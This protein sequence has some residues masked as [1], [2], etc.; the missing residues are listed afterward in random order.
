MNSP[1]NSQQ[2]TVRPDLLLSNFSLEM[3]AK[4]SEALADAAP[5]L[6]PGT[7][8]SITYLPGETSAARVA[9]A[10]LVRQLGFLP[11]PHIS[12][13]RLTSQVE[14]DDCL[15]D[16]A[17]EAGL[18]R[19]FVVAGDCDP[20]GPFSDA[21]DIIRSGRLSSFGVVR[22]GIAGYPEG[23]PAIPNDILWRALSDKHQLLLELGH[24][25]I[26]TTQFA[27]D[28]DAMLTWVEEVRSRGITSTIRLGV[29]GPASVK[30]LLRF[31]ARCGVG[32][33]AKVLRKYGISI[34]Q[35]LKV[36]VPDRMI[37]ELAASFD[38]AVH[39]D[40]RIH[41]YPFGGLRNM[42]EWAGNFVRPAK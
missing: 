29:P 32:A 6:P 42:A 16:L 17:R 37:Q 39:G 3:T 28:I 22:V 8:V 19:C 1:D 10:R 36:A 24:E 9:A 11:I 4:D 40:L 33:S 7:P 25:P 18:D 23:H 14:L 38:L 15:G 5:L 34:T 27:F 20:K 26:I 2:E 41:F 13:R 31:A 30:L 35:L 12:A 21:L